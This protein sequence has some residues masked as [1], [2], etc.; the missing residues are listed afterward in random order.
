MGEG[1][2][3]ERRMGMDTKA[4]K[5]PTETSSVIT[6]R[7]DATNFLIV[8]LTTLTNKRMKPKEASKKTTVARNVERAPWKTWGPVL[9][10]QQ[11]S[12]GNHLKKR[13][14]KGGCNPGGLAGTLLKC[15][16][17]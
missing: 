2:T 3:R 6:W 11:F 8:N 7:S 15:T 10:N 13:P 14:Y 17:L 5:R 4:W 1:P 16:Y 12:I 9:I